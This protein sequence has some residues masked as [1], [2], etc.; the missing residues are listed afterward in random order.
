MAPG[1]TFENSARDP[2]RRPTI[3]IRRD[4]LIFTVVSPEAL[5]P[6]TDGSLWCVAGRVLSVKRMSHSLAFVQLAV[7]CESPF[8]SF[9]REGLPFSTGVM[10]PETWQLVLAEGK[11][12][13]SEGLAR[14]TAQLEIGH[15]MW[16]VYG[17]GTAA[18]TPTGMRTV[19]VL[20]IL[21]AGSTTRPQLN[22]ETLPTTPSVGMHVQPAQ[23]E[24]R[25][26]AG[27]NALRA[28]KPGVTADVLPE[29]QVHKAEGAVQKSKRFSCFAQWL[30]D[31][32]GVAFLKVGGGVMDIAGA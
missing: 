1:L 24:G 10:K 26:A 30:V 9:N 6:C 12:W 13:Q 32:W 18:R 17:T 7:D 19:D 20:H 16:A 25:C 28:G 8:C 29:W 14:L 27:G 23:A 21:G 15:Q 5:P 2:R 11:L 3:T 31:M 22:G 4:P